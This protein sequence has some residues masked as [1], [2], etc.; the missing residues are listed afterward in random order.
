VLGNGTKQYKANPFCIRFV[1]LI[2][3]NFG[4]L[5]SSALL[6]CF[7]KINVLLK[8]IIFLITACNS[9]N[10][11]AVQPGVDSSHSCMQ[12]PERFEKPVSIIKKL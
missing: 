9:N 11:N 10:K 2:L 6:Q 12:M 8:V 7:M 4:T 1:K 5:L 3:I